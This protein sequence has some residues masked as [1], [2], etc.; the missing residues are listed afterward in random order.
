MTQKIP[1]IAGKVML[2]FNN[3]SRASVPPIDKKTLDT[4]TIAYLKLLNCTTKINTIKINQI[5]I[6]VQRSLIL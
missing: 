1:I 6:A 3:A 4:I 5:I 2:I